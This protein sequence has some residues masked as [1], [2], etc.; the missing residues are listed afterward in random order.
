MPLKPGKKNQGKNI[1]EMMNSPTFAPDQSPE[2][3]QQM[4]VAASYH[5]LGET[6]QESRARKM[7]EGIKARRGK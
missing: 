3:R 2:K 5:K 4:A 7:V 6:P 1:E